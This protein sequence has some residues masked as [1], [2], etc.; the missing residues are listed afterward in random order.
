MDET[1]LTL[2][3]RGF[4]YCEHAIDCRKY[5]GFVPEN[6]YSQVKIHGKVVR[7]D[8]HDLDWEN[9]CAT[10][11]IEIHKEI[12]FEDWLKLCTDSDHLS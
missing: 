3:E 6:K 11:M 5:Y 7:T 4:H 2:C 12:N 1:T 9:K 10:N 8:E